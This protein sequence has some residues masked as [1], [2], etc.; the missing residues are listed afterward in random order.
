VKHGNLEMVK[1]ILN[2]VPV[3]VKEILFNQKLNDGS[4]ALML[5][6]ESLNSELIQFLMENNVNEDPKNDGTTIPMK[7]VSKHLFE[8]AK[9]FLKKGH[10][11]FAKD[12]MGKDLLFIITESLVFIN[13]KGILFVEFLIDNGFSPNH[14]METIK[15]TGEKRI[16]TVFQKV[17]YN[18]ELAMKMIQL[19]AD[20]VNFEKEI[21][22]FGYK[23]KIKEFRGEIQDPTE[24]V[25]YHNDP[26]KY[27][28]LCVIHNRLDILKEISS[29]LDCTEIVD[30]NGNNIL[31]LS[32]IS[33]RMN[34]F[35]FIMKKLNFKTM[36]NQKNNEGLLPLHIALQRANYN[37]VRIFCEKSDSPLI[38]D[39][40]CFEK[41]RIHRD[42]FDF[43]RQWKCM[44][45]SKSTDI[46]FHFR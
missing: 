29:Q 28:F 34:I 21:S 39:H 4:S 1:M 41:T 9:H 43:L 30:S 7:L 17:Q 15:W 16:M 18:T 26:V 19:G 11:F 10:D 38:I 22:N 40:L 20:Y 8:L 13:P 37:A 6:I 42:L 31:G 14:E 3:E 25:P 23:K 35:E 44:E 12:Q 5:A 32:L 2:C 36:M 46:H 24:V 27:L 33:Y 45:N